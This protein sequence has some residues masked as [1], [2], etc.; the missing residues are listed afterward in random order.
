MYFGERNPP[1]SHVKYNDYRAQI[2]IETL[3]IIEG[4]LPPKAFSLVVKWAGI[5]QKELHKN[6]LSILEKGT[7]IKINPL[8]D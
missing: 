1:H 5:H 2:D 6:W 4:H 7:F 3:G 8:E